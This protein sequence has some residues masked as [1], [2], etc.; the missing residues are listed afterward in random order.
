MVQDWFSARAHCGNQYRLK[1][2]GRPPPSFSP[3]GRSSG[4][5]GP[6]ADKPQLS[7]NRTATRPHGPAAA[8]RRRLARHHRKNRI[9]GSLSD[10]SAASAQGVLPDSRL[11]GS[12][13][14]SPLLWAKQKQGGRPP[15]RIPGLE[16]QPTAKAE[17]APKRR[18]RLRQHAATR[19]PARQGQ[20]TR[21]RHFN[22]SRASS[23]TSS[24]T[25]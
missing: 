14:L 13:F 24:I 3:K 6:T 12:P 25:A 19:T 20:D 10:R 11:Q 5:P 9:S 18:P 23:L 1:R 22:G 8:Q 15:G 17:A 4:Y 2:A 21:L 7:G 16:P